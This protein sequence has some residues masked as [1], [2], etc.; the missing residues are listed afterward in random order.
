MSKRQGVPCSDHTIRV[1]LLSLVIM[2][3]VNAEEI[4]TGAC[5]P[6][7]SRVHQIEIL[8][9]GH[10]NYGV[11]QDISFISSVEYQ[12]TVVDK[13]PSS[14]T[15]TY[16][17]PLFTEIMPDG[18]N[19]KILCYDDRGISDLYRTDIIFDTVINNTH[20][21]QIECSFNRTPIQGKEER[22]INIVFEAQNF[23]IANEQDLAYPFNIFGLFSIGTETDEEIAKQDLYVILPEDYELQKVFASPEPPVLDITNWR[24]T[25]L[26]NED[27]EY[28]IF[29]PLKK[30]ENKEYLIS[31]VGNQKSVI[32][33]FSLGNDT[34]LMILFRGWGP[35]ILSIILIFIFR[36]FK[37]DN[38]WIM[39]GIPFL[40]IGSSIFIVGEYTPLMGNSIINL[41]NV[42][43]GILLVTLIVLLINLHREKR[44]SSIAR[45]YR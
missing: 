34:I 30:N 36:H 9:G 27:K 32:G 3:V 21:V 28:P 19:S 31:N 12:G 2:T 22:T 33:L 5:G 25:Y 39:A 7:L 18:I 37:F 38:Q 26:Y 13:E 44:E 16:S 11:R 20:I 10:A 45:S 8:G 43:K 24:V 29:Q 40:G 23:Y 4:V 41:Y 15:V 14:M 42:V 6:V 35:G 17:L 1:V